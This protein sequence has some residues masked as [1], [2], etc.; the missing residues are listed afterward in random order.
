ME[1]KAFSHAIRVHL[2]EFG[3]IRV[4]SNTHEA[5][6]CL[7]YCWPG[8]RGPRHRDAID[9]CLKVLDG[10]R[11]TVDAEKAFSDAVSEAGM[12]IEGPAPR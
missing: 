9:A 1:E 4:V 11:S 8:D 3:K 2:V 7:M 6:D 10:H 5:L 12:L